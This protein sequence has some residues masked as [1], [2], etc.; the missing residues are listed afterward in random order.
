MLTLESMRRYTFTFCLTFATMAYPASKFGDYFA[1]SFLFEC[2][3][4]GVG[5]SAS[6][7]LPSATNALLLITTSTLLNGLTTTG[8]NF[9]NILG[10]GRWY[11]EP[12]FIAEMRLD[13]QPEATKQFIKIFAEGKEALNFDLS[14]YNSRMGVMVLYAVAL[15]VLTY[16]IWR[17]RLRSK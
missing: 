4:F 6:V 1:A 10:W 8:Q 3:V 14:S 9:Q 15:R 2:M 17:F 11:S 12:L 13:I 5:Y 7:L 16:A